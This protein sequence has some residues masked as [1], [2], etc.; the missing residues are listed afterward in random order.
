[1]A[2]FTCGMVLVALVLS[3][4]IQTEATYSI[5]PVSVI[6]MTLKTLSETEI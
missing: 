2:A 1:M 5:T 6:S 3:P 4:S